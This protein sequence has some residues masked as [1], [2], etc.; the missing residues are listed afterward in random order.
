MSR[1]QVPQNQRGTQ[2]Q[3]NQGYRQQSSRI[4]QGY[5]Q[6]RPR[7][8]SSQQ[9][10][11][12]GYPQQRPQQ[13]YQRQRP[14]Q[15]YQQR[16]LQQ[17]YQQQRPRQDYQSQ[18]PQQG[19]PQQ[20]PRQDYQQQRPRDPY[21]E[22]SQDYYYQDEDYYQ[23]QGY[24]DD[25]YYQD[26]YYSQ[27]VPP[28]NRGTGKKSK[29]KKTKKDYILL[30]V[31]I[32]CV[33]AMLF[34]GFQLFRS[35]R[36]YK[37]ASDEYDTIEK[38][39][40]KPSSNESDVDESHVKPKGDH[41]KKKL[42]APIDVDF[43]SLQ[44][45]NP[46]LVGWIYVEGLEGVSYPVV[47]GD[48]NDKYLHTTFQG[49][50]NFAGTIFI[51]C[52][53]RSDFEDCNTVIY[54]HNMKDGSMFGRLKWFET[55][56]AYAVSPYIWILTP[57]STMKYE[58]FATYETPINSRTYTLF[59]K[60]S[61]DYLKYEGE[62]KALSAIKTNDVSLTAKSKIITLSTCTGNEGTR[63]VVQAVRVYK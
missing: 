41:T 47:K 38:Q 49:T 61:K 35:Y 54:G 25:G 1:Q 46:D 21:Y 27:Q 26:D 15:D 12:Q 62:M 3:P 33:I 50:Y 6:Q 48:T 23:N 63:Y 36:Q 10:H 56:N 22:D 29:K 30:V 34:S 14:Q 17:G 18:R 37:I 43:A 57:D 40:V 7:N 58:I 9:S 45:T 60:P 24:Y 32:A 42:K 39:A 16:R 31:I 8:G 4:Q 52:Q 5:P 59:P 20:R 51:D 53:N 55:Q 44:A 2:R 13:D 19:Y 11:Q 28:S